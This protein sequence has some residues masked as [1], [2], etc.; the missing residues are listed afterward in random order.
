MDLITE[1][2][3]PAQT[4]FFN[5]DPLGNQVQTLSICNGKQI[6]DNVQI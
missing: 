4:Y 2:T 1:Q 3:L 5:Q 6:C